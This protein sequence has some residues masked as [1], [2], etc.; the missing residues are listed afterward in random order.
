[1]A[2]Q[3]LLDITQSILNDMD[4]DEVN[5]ISDTVESEQ[6]AQIVKDTFYEIIESRTWPHLDK[7]IQLSPQGSTRPTHMD[8]TSTWN[9]VA[10]IKYNQRT[11]TDTKDKYIDITYMSPKDFTDYLDARDSSATDVTSVSDPSGIT[12]LILNDKAPTFWTTFDD[13]VL[14]FDSYD[15]VV[16]TNLQASKTQVFGSVSPSWVHTD[17]AIPDLPAKAFSYLLSESKS[18]AFNALRQVGNSK[19]EQRSRRQR[20]RLSREKWVVNG[21]MQFPDYGRRV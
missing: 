19:E 12:L 3:T 18:T 5:S 11:S 7:L 21:G 9:S 17:T 14:I 15:K 13:E 8:T 10:W 6:V 20:I 16:D 4:S 2:K 1:M